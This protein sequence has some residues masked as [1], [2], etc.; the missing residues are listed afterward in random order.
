MIRLK[1]MTAI[2]WFGDG[3]LVAPIKG[4]IHDQ[5]VVGGG[6]TDI[7]LQQGVIGLAL[8]LEGLEVSG[9]HITWSTWRCLWFQR[10]GFG[11]AR[12]VQS[13]FCTRQQPQ[14][15]L[16]RQCSANSTTVTSLT[17]CKLYTPSRNI[18]KRR[19][20]TRCRPSSPIRTL[21]EQLSTHTWLCR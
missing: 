4:A 12:R 5:V 13:S 17:G 7:I 21:C 14:S 15:C 20:G 9:D 6:P 16:G 18:S 8:K 1:V 2:T 11:R 10:A 3:G 19:T